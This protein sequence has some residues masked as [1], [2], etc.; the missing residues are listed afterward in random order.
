MLVSI[1][2]ETRKLE[3]K[4]NKPESEIKMK[5]NLKESIC[6]SKRSIP[7]SSSSS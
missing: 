3:M 2:F 6:L 1:G 5:K 7:S 4:K